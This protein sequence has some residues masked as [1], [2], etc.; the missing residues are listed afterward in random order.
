MHP[1]GGLGEG[2]VMANFQLLMLNPN[3]LKSQS[4][5]ALPR[6]KGVCDGQLPTFDA[7][8]KS[9]KIPKSLCTPGGTWGGGGA[10]DS[11]LSATFSADLLWEFGVHYRKI[12]QI[13][14]IQ[15]EWVHHR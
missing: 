2:L 14:T 9:A 6:G 3:L 5:Y 11:Q 4:P 10:G 15:T 1:M 7:E 8:S 12:T 13:F